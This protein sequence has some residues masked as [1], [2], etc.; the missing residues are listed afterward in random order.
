MQQHI[1]TNV[2]CIIPYIQNY[3]NYHTQLKSDFNNQTHLESITHKVL[4]EIHVVLQT[5]ATG[6]VTF[7]EE[8]R[9]DKVLKM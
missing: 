2:T 8:N 5:Y 3:N 6:K 9:G 7:D 1:H 4:S